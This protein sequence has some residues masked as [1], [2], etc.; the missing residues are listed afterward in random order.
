M[1]DEVSNPTISH[2]IGLFAPGRPVS[3]PMREPLYHG[4]HT[5]ASDK[6]YSDGGDAH[7]PLTG[8]TERRPQVGGQRR[9]LL[10]SELALG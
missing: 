6:A 3:W 10:D 1:S 4:L 7:G 5:S 8:N 2:A 9:F